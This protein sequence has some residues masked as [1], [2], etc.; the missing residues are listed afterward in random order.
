[1]NNCADCHINA[2]FISYLDTSGA[3]V[4]YQTLRP[5]S[6]QASFLPPPLP[7]LPPPPTPHPGGRSHISYAAKIPIIA[8]VPS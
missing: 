2:H 7:R 1:M 3:R 4:V 8:S 6:P 5:P